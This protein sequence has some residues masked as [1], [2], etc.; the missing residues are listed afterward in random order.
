MEEETHHSEE[1]HEAP[2]EHQKSHEGK[3][4]TIKKD[5]LWKYSTFVLIAVVVIGALLMISGG[6]NTGTG[7]A[8]GPVD[9]GPADMSAFL[10]NIDIYPSLGPIDAENVVV[11]FSDFQCPFCTLVTGLPDWTADFQS[12]YGPL[13]GVAKEVEDMARAGDIRFIYVPWSFLG[14]ESENAAQAALCANEQ[15]KFWEMHDAIFLASDGPEE[16]TGK[17]A[18]DKLKIIARGVTNLDMTTFNSCLD[19]GEYTSALSRIS[20]DVRAVGVTGTPTFFV[21]G[22]KVSPSLAEIKAALN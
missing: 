18:I 22:E 16:H 8:V 21:N 17:Y 7:S 11:E 10:S 12:Q 4:I 2:R 19:G 1:N 5:D 15:G 20:S 13:I 3:T 9:N 14:E 6:G